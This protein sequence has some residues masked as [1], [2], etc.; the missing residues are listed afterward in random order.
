MR[1]I[2]HMLFGLVSISFCL[3]SCTQPGSESITKMQFEKIIF[4]SSRCYG[5]C[6]QIDFQVDSTRNIFINRKYFKSKSEED[7][8]KSGSFKGVLDIDTY[9]DLLQILE[10]SDY[11]NLKFPDITCCDGVI[12]TII[13][14]SNNK[15]T[16]LKSMTPPKE[17]SALIA[18]LHKLGTESELTKISDAI[19][20]EE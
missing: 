14:Y 18:F 8:S 10:K 17:S 20:L 13:I 12:T 16:Y 5:S 11:T 19:T 4:H 2:K 9:N 1:S 7:K 3:S 15:R 6:P